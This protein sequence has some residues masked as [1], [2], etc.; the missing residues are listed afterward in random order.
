MSRYASKMDIDTCSHWG[1]WESC[2]IGQI[3]HPHF[4]PPACG[5]PAD[6]WFLLSPRT[7]QTG[8]IE[9][10]VRCVEHEIIRRN[11]FEPVSY[12]EACCFQIMHS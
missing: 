7:S 8:E 5:A 11:G 1:P 10:V 4:H 6:S 9:L 2:V 3:S 12:A